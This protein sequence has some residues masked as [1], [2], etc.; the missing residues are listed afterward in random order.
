MITEWGRNISPDN[1]W[2][3][4]PRPQLERKSWTNLNGL[5][6]FAVTS[7]DLHAPA[8]WDGKFLV[9]FCP[10]SALSGVGRLTEPNETLWYKR[11]LPDPQKRMRTLLNFEA[12]DYETTVWVNGHKVGSHTGG[13]TPFSFDITS[14]LKPAGNELVVRVH[15]ATEGF[16]LHGKQKLNPGGIWYTR[17]TGIWQTVWLESVPDRFIRDLD[18]TTDANSARLLVEPHLSAS[19]QEGEKLRVTASIAGSIV[20]TQSGCPNVVI[21]IPQAKL[22]SPQAPNLY[23]L[24]VEW[25]DASGHAIDAVKSYVAI[26]EFGKVQD[27]NG[28]WRFTLNGKKIFHWG[29]LDQGWWPDGLLTP[30]SES[31]MVSDIDYL[32]AAGFN[33][34]RKHIKIEPRRYYAHCDKVGMM[35]WQ[36]H[37]SMGFGPQ[38]EPKGS[39]PRWSHLAPDPIDGKWPAVAHKQFI[40]EY[41]RMVDHLR[42]VPCLA[43]W[44]PFNEAWGQH[45]TM[46][47]GKIAESYDKTRLINIASGGNF[48]PIGDIADEHSYPDPAFPLHENRFDD[49]V[50]VIGEFGGHGIPIDGHLWS[51]TA[52]NWGY[53]NLPK[54]L[55]EWK[56]RY[57]RSIRILASLR[58]RGIAG[59][60]YTQTTDVEHEI[61]GFRTYDRV[62]KI[63]PDWLRSLSQMLL[64][65]PDVVKTQILTPTSETTPQS[66]RFTTDKPAD[67]WETP[68]F[69]DNSWLSGKG[70]FGAIE[71]IQPGTSWNTGNIWIRRE[72]EIAKVPEGQLFLR[73]FHDENAVVFLNGQNIANTNGFVTGYIDLPI[74]HENV[75]EPGRNVIA[76]HCSQ[77]EGGQFIDAGI[78]AESAE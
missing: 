60:V 52:A 9:P 29:P 8:D 61:N 70:G 74:V 55:D 72:F 30:P 48:W 12:V 36:D 57:A 22:W 16:K 68:D 28:N 23:D 31:A 5:W 20:A 45:E 21:H 76:I 54:D 4:Y 19:P 1:A 11:T 25:L 42:D 35:I 46:S 63:D 71:G 2:P 33:M 69:D 56:E 50:K 51:K 38:T 44:V 62:N 75:L 39:N 53:G 59:G 6:D 18:F 13:F 65:T 64:D 66:W 32:K 77:S 49:Y 26:R 67:G 78:V 73:I 24:K 27:A 34:I 10:E 3:E 14:A 47:V 43:V 58:K 41:K 15:D 40:T 17:V 7:K 37:V